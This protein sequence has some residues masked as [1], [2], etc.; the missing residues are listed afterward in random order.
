MP[1]LPAPV[2]RY[3][4]RALPEEPSLIPSATLRQSGELRMSTRA[5]RHDPHAGVVAI[6]THTDVGL[7]RCLITVKAKMDHI[8]E[9]LTVPQTPSKE[10]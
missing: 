10:K 1:E 3:L 9:A 5:R 8:E 7:R 4:R 2:L 6:G